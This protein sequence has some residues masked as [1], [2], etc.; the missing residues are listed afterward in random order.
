MN[1]TLLV[2]MGYDT[3]SILRALSDHQ[4][5][6]GDKFVFIIPSTETDRTKVMKS[7]VER[8]FLVLAS[9]GIVLGCE[10]VIVDENDFTKTFSALVHK[11]V[12]EEGQQIIVEIAG[13]LR[14]ICLALLLAT[15]MLPNRVQQAYAIAESSSRRIAIPLPASGAKMSFSSTT[16]IRELGRGPKTMDQLS[17]TLAK[18]KSTLNR[19]I[20]HL[21]DDGM[22]KYQREGRII[23]YS[24]TLFGSA[25][26]ANLGGLERQTPERV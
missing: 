22:V 25:Y 19:Q 14:V 13:G 3:G 16:L 21:V 11:I 17:R 18:D 5:Q 10:F 15:V 9:R 7:E 12:A 2:P 20:R 6:S 1:K 24:L 4:L 26:L 8:A 23:R